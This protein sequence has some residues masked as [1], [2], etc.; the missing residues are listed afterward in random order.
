MSHKDKLS[1]SLPLSPK[2]VDKSVGNSA[3]RI[4]F[5]YK[6]QFFILMLKKQ[7]ITNKLL[8]FITLIMAK[9]CLIGLFYRFFMPF[10][11]PFCRV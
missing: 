2:S 11:A 4:V 8:F 3:P 7:A 1:F 5:A 10:K 9:A 6:T